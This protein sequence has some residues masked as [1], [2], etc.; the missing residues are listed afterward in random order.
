MRRTG[1]VPTEVDRTDDD[2]E[3]ADGEGKQTPVAFD[4]GQDQT[5]PSRSR[6]PGLPA[7]SSIGRELRL[8]RTTRPPRNSW[9][10]VGLWAIHSVIAVSASART[11]PAIT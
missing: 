7:D 11:T 3:I 10:A 2:D 8:D 4:S 1:G 5:V 6:P 9:C